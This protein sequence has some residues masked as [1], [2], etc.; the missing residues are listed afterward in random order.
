[1]VARNA[2]R[3][4]LHLATDESLRLHVF[5]DHS[6]VEVYANEGQCLTKNIYPSRSDSQGIALFARGG[7]LVVR[8]LN[9]WQMATIWPQVYAPE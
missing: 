7:E 2:Q 1:M 6:I 9:A 4:P 8:S 5:L 3:G